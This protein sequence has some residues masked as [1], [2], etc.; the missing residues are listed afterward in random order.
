VESR[1]GIDKLTGSRNVDVLLRTPE[2]HES[3]WSGSV[4]PTGVVDIAL[5]ALPPSSV[6]ELLVVEGDRELARSKLLE[7]ANFGRD[8]TRRGGFVEPRHPPG[9]D[10]R[11][12]VE[13]GVLA[14]PFPDSLVFSLGRAGDPAVGVVIELEAD[15]A[16]LASKQ[17]VTDERGRARILVTPREHTVTVRV[18]A[19]VGA[20]EL[21]T[22]VALPVV[23]GAIDA[24]RVGDKLRVSSPVPRDQAFVTLVT[25]RHRLFGASLELRPH[26]EGGSS[27]ELVLPPLPDEP[28]WAVTSS[29]PDLESPARVG[30]PLNPQETEARKTFDVPER[31]RV[32]GLPVALRRELARQKR[33]RW[34]VV[35]LCGVALL[36]ELLLLAKASSNAEAELERHFAKSGLSAGGGPARSGTIVVAL[37]ILVL[38]FALLAVFAFLAES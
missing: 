20:E 32:D 1:R 35:A 18:R 19:A 29:A 23:P 3:V 4:P 17:V 38:A 9:I 37:L 16:E 14:V 30:W 10:F 33:V 11:M 2:G 28:V 24:R 7:P 25:E 36:L 8:A 34:S 31:L 27:A 21:Q 15:G 5:P 12:G 6:Q 26:A 22:S 13:R